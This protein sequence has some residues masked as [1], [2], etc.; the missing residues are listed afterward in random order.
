MPAYKWLRRSAGT[1]VPHTAVEGGRDVDGSSIYVGRAFHEGDMIPAKVIPDKNVAYVAWGGQ[2]HP[3]SSYEVLCQGEFSW[4]FCG[5]GRIPEDAVVGGQTSEGEP[6]YIG[7]VI[8]KGSQTIGKVQGSHGVLYIPFDG[9]ELSFNDY[10]VL[11][12]H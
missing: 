11:V 7:R 9:E 8:H 4:E 12:L 5:N 3:K 6:L 10:E 2:E 1:P